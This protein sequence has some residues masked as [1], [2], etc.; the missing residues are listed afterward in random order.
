MVYRNLHYFNTFRYLFHDF[1]WRLTIFP[2]LDEHV[3]NEF[4]THLHYFATKSVCFCYV[5]L[6]MDRCISECSRMHWTNEIFI[7][8]FLFLFQNIFVLFY[9]TFSIASQLLQKKLMTCEY[10]QKTGIVLMWQNQRIIQFIFLVW[11]CH[12]VLTSQFSFQ[13]RYI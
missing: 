7:N 5:L 10:L 11:L 9:F 2:L 6:K 8:N 1:L 3:C 4:G 12:F 13:G